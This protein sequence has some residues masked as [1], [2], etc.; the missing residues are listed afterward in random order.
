MQ[1]IRHSR[2]ETILHLS[3]MTE[4]EGMEDSPSSLTTT[5]ISTQVNNSLLTVAIIPVTGIITIITVI[6]L[7]ILTP[8]EITTYIPLGGSKYTNKD[9]TSSSQS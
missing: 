2:H 1:M 9:W 4:E 8:E 6:V 3:L 5:T 7:L